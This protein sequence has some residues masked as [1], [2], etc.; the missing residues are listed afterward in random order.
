MIFVS[1]WMSEVNYLFVIGG[2][3][4]LLGIKEWLEKKYFKILNDLEMLNV[5]GLL[6]LVNRS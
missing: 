3:V 6:K 5:C 4:Y 2:G 1:E